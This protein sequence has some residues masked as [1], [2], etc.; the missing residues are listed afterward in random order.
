MA[1]FGITKELGWF[2]CFA[3]YSKPDSRFKINK[4][5]PV[6]TYSYGVVAVTGVKPAF[7]LKLILWY[8]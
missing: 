7:F 2:Y 4:L 1:G 5:S 8:S 3:V 6:N